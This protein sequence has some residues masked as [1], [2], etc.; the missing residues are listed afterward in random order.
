MRIL[1]LSLLM[2]ASA[3]AAQ[4]HSSMQTRLVIVDSCQ[5]IRSS[6]VCQSGISPKITYSNEVISQDNNQN[7]MTISY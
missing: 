5:S 3:H 1:F 2:L 6:I 4:N 7:V